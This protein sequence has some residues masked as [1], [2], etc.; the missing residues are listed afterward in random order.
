MSSA[1][2]I[3]FQY[4]YLHSK[5]HENENL[6]LFAFYDPGAS[7]TLNKEFENYLVNRFKEGNPDRLFLLPHNT[8]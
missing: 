2:L 8:K 7:F 6:H 3:Y 1:H 4:R 5:V